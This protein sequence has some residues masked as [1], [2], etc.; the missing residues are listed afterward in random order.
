MTGLN[1]HT[2]LTAPLTQLLCVILVS[3]SASA[4]TE[5]LLNADFEYDT[6]NHTVF[7]EETST[8]QNNGTITSWLW[9]FGD[10]NTSVSPEPIYA[11]ANYGTY[12]CCLT[13]TTTEEDGSNCQHTVC[14]DVILTQAEPCLVE[15]GFDHNHL[16][17]GKVQFSEDCFA[18]GNTSISSFMWDFGDGSSS[19]EANP[20]H[21]Y[22]ESGHFTVCL[23]VTGTQDGVTC[24]DDFCMD[25]DVDN[26][27]CEVQPAIKVRYQTGCGINMIN[28]TSA[29]NFTEIVAYSWDFGDGNYS[30]EVS[31][32]HFYAENGEYEVCL[33]VL[34]ECPGNSCEIQYC[35]TVI[36]DCPADP[37]HQQSKPSRG[38]QGV[39]TSIN[40]DY[41]QALTDGKVY[42]NPTSG[43]LFVEMPANYAYNIYSSNGVLVMTG[44]MNPGLNELDLE[45]LEKGIYL[46]EYTDGNQRDT[47][48]IVLQ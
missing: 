35:S 38:D 20:L 26:F 6:F 13:V 39:T 22:E 5:C 10:G 17:N 37:T 28:Y 11:Y 12:Y 1:S 31:P 45:Q 27:L 16:E 48:R 43:Q 29:Q 19:E 8:N 40:R 32:L 34:A 15:S 7:F 24:T 36:V 23:V 2:L 42:P 44:T 41:N 21:Q 25:V 3:V 14:H 46:L 47:Q 33:T 4:Q 9:E 30:D 18:N